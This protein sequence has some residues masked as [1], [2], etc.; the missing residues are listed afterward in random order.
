M[1][2]AEMPYTRRVTDEE[3][4]T[5]G[6]S[7]AIFF[8]LAHQKYDALN[9]SVVVPRKRSVELDIVGDHFY[10]YRSQRECICRDGLGIGSPVVPP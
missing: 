4:Y 1:E 6:V 2:V 9:S 8:L 7:A 3:R 10:E 5:R